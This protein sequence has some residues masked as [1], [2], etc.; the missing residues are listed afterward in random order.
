MADPLGLIATL[1][2]GG[3]CGVVFRHDAAP[4]RL[5]LGTAIAQI[6]RARGIALVVAGDAR[7]AARLHAG[8]HLR[9]GRRPGRLALPRNRPITASVHH[10]ADLHRARRNG[11]TILFCSPVFPTASHPG[12]PSLG[13]LGFQRLA[14]HAGAAERYALGGIDGTAIRRLGRVC[15]GA[16]AID[17]F[18]YESDTDSRAKHNPGGRAIRRKNPRPDTAN[19]RQNQPHF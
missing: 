18:L 13:S 10:A 16:G 8:L 11:A 19:S 7:L 5:A 3:L 2:K 9:G 12:A 6:C 1:P 14:R 17:A 15:A 4:N